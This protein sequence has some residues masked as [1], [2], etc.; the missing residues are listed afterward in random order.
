MAILEPALAETTA[1]TCMVIVREAMDEAVR[2]GVPYE[3]ARDFLLGHINIELAIVFGEVSSPF[4]DGAKL[5]IE[6]GKQILF[7]PDWK[8]LFEPEAIRTEID[9]ITKGTKN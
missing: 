9:A 8:R 7:K 4:S 6:R 1:A 2:R 3:A 5:A